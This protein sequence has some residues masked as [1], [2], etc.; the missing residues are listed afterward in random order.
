LCTR[1]REFVLS[2][3]LGQLEEKFAYDVLRIHRNCLANRHHLFGFGAQLVEGESRWFAVLH[4]WPE[5]L[6][7][8][9]R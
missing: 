7:V 9:A 2:D 4:E 1:E 6:L 5:Q 3:S 8:S